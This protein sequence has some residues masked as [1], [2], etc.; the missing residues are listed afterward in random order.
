MHE[1]KAL[2]LVKPKDLYWISVTG[3]STLNIAKLHYK[4]EYLVLQT[5]TARSCEIN[6][7]KYSRQKLHCIR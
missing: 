1:G 4:R 6:Q 5:E 7:R 2:C 3:S